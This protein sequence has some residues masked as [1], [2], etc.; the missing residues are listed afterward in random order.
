MPRN[1]PLNQLDVVMDCIRYPIGERFG[2][3]HALTNIE[4]CQAKSG[5][6]RP[7]D[8]LIGFLY[9]LLNSGRSSHT[10]NTLAIGKHGESKGQLFNLKI[11]TAWI[12]VWSDHITL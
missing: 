11:G 2:V 5:P 12:F 8:L 3:G 10:A 9:Y 7:L 4:D 1:R 6:V